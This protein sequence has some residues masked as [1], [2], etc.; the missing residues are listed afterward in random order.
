MG[1]LTASDSFDM[2][3]EDSP[4]HMERIAADT[5]LQ[6]PKHGNHARVQD[7]K[8]A[9]ASAGTC[10]MWQNLRNHLLLQGKRV[11]KGSLRL[12]KMIKTYRRNITLL[13]LTRHPS[14]LKMVTEG[15]GKEKPN[16][17]NGMTR[18]IMVHIKVKDG[19]ND[20]RED[21]NITVIGLKLCYF[22]EENL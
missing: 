16:P 17:L 21:R 13:P 1:G 6:S 2:N 8:C 12:N 20:T 15:K 11:A 14:I 18:V 7:T 10:H 5:S 9:K 3:L 19:A 4:S 22:P